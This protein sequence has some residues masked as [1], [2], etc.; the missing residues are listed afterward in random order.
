[1]TFSITLYIYIRINT[2][3]KCNVISSSCL[4]N[5][6]SKSVT[7]PPGSGCRIN[8]VRKIYPQIELPRLGCRQRCKLIE[9]GRE[10]ALWNEVSCITIVMQWYDT[11]CLQCPWNVEVTLMFVSLLLLQYQL[12]PCCKLYHVSKKLYCWIIHE[13]Q[14]QVES[15]SQLISTEPCSILTTEDI[16]C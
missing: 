16:F 6:Y 2:R 3:N 4:C 5:N 13:Q 15:S 8:D 14:G 9:T 10:L 1:M 12:I 7:I 11:S